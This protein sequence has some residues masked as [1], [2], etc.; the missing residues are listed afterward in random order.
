MPDPAAPGAP[1]E[2][3]AH[4]TAAVRAAE[5]A[6]SDRL[7]EDPWAESLAGAEGRAW[8]AGRTV[9]SVQPM[10]LRTRYY[11]DWLASVTAGPDGIRRV[12]LLAAGLDT[13]AYRLEWPPGSHVFELDRPAVLS[14]KEQV[15]KLATA[16]C[17]RHAVGTDI[18]GDWGRALL[19]AGF[20]PATP[21]AWLLKG[22]LFYLPTDAIVRV[23][24][25]V[26]RLAVPGSRLGFDIINGEVLAFPYTRAWIEMQ[27]AAG[28]PWLGWL[29][30]P[31][32]FLGDRNWEAHL[33]AAG[34]PA[35]N[36]GRWTLPVLPTTMPGMP[37]NWLVTAVKG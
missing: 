24:D 18:T 8:I 27:A 4:W 30:D 36:H 12:V 33:T 7:F 11:D 15:L 5:T 14:H 21:A 17:T 23:L 3:T 9:E 22:F 19:D 10:V 25:E 20:D 2:A 31:V 16:S 32:G 13:R 35:A 6:R 34:E 29:D 26:N 37:H 28:A 1:L